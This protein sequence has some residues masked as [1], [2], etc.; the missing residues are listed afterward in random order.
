MGKS[1]KKIVFTDKKDL[2][3]PKK[4][5]TIFHD[6]MKASMTVG[7]NTPKPKKAA[8]KKTT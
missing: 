5:S 1:N 8:K 6:I 7:L 2:K 3:S 4:A